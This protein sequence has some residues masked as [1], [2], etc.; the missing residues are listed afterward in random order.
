MS[1]PEAKVAAGIERY[2]FIDAIRGYVILA[3]TLL[4]RTLALVAF[5]WRHDMANHYGA[6]ATISTA[7]ASAT[8]SLGRAGLGVY[9]RSGLIGPWHA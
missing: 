3:V 8:R 1:V 4:F 6:A 2:A 7:G 9:V 5:S